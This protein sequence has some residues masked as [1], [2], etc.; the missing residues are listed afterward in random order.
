MVG[1]FVLV[2]NLRHF[3]SGRRPSGD[4]LG[5]LV[6]A[7]TS[8]IWCQDPRTSSRTLLLNPA[9]NAASLIGQ[10]NFIH[11]VGGAIFRRANI[12][13]LA[14]SD[15]LLWTMNI[16]EHKCV[17]YIVFIF[18]LLTASLLTAATKA[19]SVAWRLPSKTPTR[20]PSLSVAKL[21]SGS[22]SSRVSSQKPIRSG[23]CADSE[24]L[25][26]RPGY[27]EALSR[28][29]GQTSTQNLHNRL[30]NSKS[31]DGDKWNSVCKSH[32]IHCVNLWLFR[33]NASRIPLIF[34]LSASSQ[35]RI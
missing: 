19:R 4:A 25:V 20:R 27:F 23:I 13:F 9:E 5:V 31:H 34:F 14:Y 10:K 1:N 28:H 30:K 3:T 11:G 22:C 6:E 16:N 7:R 2:K 15:C 21:S 26:S 33:I 17:M 24:K 18:L 32:L 8:R 35:S 12:F 29:R